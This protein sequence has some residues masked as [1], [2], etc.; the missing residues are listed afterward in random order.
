MFLLAALLAPWISP[1]SP[2]EQFVEDA[3]QGPSWRYLMGTDELGRD[4]LARLLH[5]ARVS[6]SVGLLTALI[7]VA[8]GTLYGAV[9][10]YRGGR[11][12]ETLMRVVEVVYSFP[13]LLVI[14]LVMMA[15]KRESAGS[16]L[17]GI[18]VALSL[19]NWAAVARVVRGEVLRLRE[20]SYV[21]SARSLGAGHARILIRHIL[22]NTLGVLVVLL[23]YRI[24]S[25]IL[26][27]STL[28]FLGL[29]IRPPYASWG[30]LANDGWVAM[31]FHPHLIVFPGL[32]IFLT[33]L[34]LYIL[35]DA[36]RD[37]LVPDRRI[38]TAR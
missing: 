4:L 1:H 22:P 10:G 2:I 26:A 11:T 38:S 20:F 24:P 17:I 9:A 25:V 36:L 19:T 5:G 7:A 28:S 33:V 23:T 21:E 31:R 13:D 30:T 35:G 8:F 37:R 32:A 15:I 27:E 12:D 29:G 6:L 14:I 3:L 18:V 16:G 34:S